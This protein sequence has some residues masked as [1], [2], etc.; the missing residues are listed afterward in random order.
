MRIS[1]LHLT[2]R[3]RNAFFGI[4][5]RRS[6]SCTTH[7]GANPA[8]NEF[9]PTFL[10]TCN[11]FLAP[12]TTICLSYYWASESTYRLKGFCLPGLGG[13]EPGL[14]HFAPRQANQVLG[15]FSDHLLFHH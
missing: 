8:K 7:C 2:F 10:A 12:T 6:F 15:H 4:S 13:A 11:Y 14:G 9:H 1:T 3:Y 5:V